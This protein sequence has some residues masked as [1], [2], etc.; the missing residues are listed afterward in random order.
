M[1]S[2]KKE[3][4]V[5]TACLS[6]FNEFVGEKGASQMKQKLNSTVFSVDQDK[7]LRPNEAQLLVVFTPPAL[8]FRFDGS[9][10]WKH[11]N[12]ILDSLEASLMLVLLQHSH[13]SSFL[14]NFY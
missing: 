12:G 4:K 14:V 13:S 3:E 7:R 1:S 8:K 6:F 10:F 5:Q 2:P 11:F 9:T